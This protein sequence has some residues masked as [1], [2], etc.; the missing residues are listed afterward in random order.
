MRCTSLALHR[1]LGVV[2]ALCALCALCALGVLGASCPDLVSGAAEGPVRVILWFDTEDYL[3]PA[4]DDAALRLARLLSARGVRATFKVV[5]EKARVLERRGRRDVI[6][7]LRSHDI[8]YHA[9]YH[10]VHPAPAE[11]LA[12]CG[13]LDGLAEF[14]RR[15]GPGAEDVRRIFGVPTLSCYGQPGSSWGPQTLGALRSIGVAPGGVPCYVDEGSHVGMGGVPFWYCGALVVYDMEPNVTRMDLHR[16]EA[17]EEGCAAF[18]KVHD[19]LA[20]EGGGLISVYYHPCEWVHREFWDGVNFRRGANPPREAWKEPPRRPAAETEAAFARF[21]KYVDFQLGLGA[22]HVTA[23]D[24]PGL[25]PDRVRSEGLDLAALGR[26]ARALEGAGAAGYVRDESGAIL[27][28]ADHLAAL[29]ALLAGAIAKGKLPERV[30]V[31][32]IFGPSEPPPETEVEELPWPAFRDA[33]LDVHDVILRR[34]QVPSAVFAGVRKIAPAD[35]L[36]ALAGAARHAIE[37][38]RDGQGGRGGKPLFPETVKVPKGTRIASEKH[39]AEDA[40]GLF[41]GWV[42][43]PEGFRAPRIVEQ[44]RL[45]AWTLKPAR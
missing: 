31:P 17:L 18:R 40:P 21:E 15:E 32:S 10:S 30:E 35:F 28:A 14:V 43:H 41:G 5:G 3:L 38:A 19:R 9:N 1:V 29:A 36:V 8:G 25:Y 39:V 16:P 11:Y 45:Q 34:G 12:A 23:S 37:A 20:A 6:E 4:S 42:I 26:V 13:W 33:L 7:A 44:A 22:K 2:R 24:L 27:S